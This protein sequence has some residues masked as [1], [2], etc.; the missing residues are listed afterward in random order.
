MQ[1]RKW[2]WPIFIYLTG[3]MMNNNFALMSEIDS[4]ITYLQFLDNVTIKNF[5]TYEKPCNNGKHI[6]QQASDVTR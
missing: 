6:C 4:E 5:N 1:Q 2:W 3:V